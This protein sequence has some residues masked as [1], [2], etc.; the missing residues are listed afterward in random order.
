MFGWIAA[1]PNTITFGAPP[2]AG[3]VITADF[4]FGYACRFTEDVA[5]FEEFMAMLS[6]V[7]TLAFQSVRDIVPFEITALRTIVIQFPDRRRASSARPSD[8]N[9][10]Y[11]RVIAIG[12]GGGGGY[13]ARRVGGGGGAFTY[14]DNVQLDVGQ[15]VPIVIGDG[16]AAA[17]PGG[18]DWGASRRPDL[19]PQSRRPQLRLCRS[20]PASIPSAS[21]RFEGAASA[22]NC[23][24]PRTRRAAAAA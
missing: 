1:Q 20:R 3:T 21:R 19:L 17:R 4:K 7:K 14:R 22:T 5:D 13:D 11:N 9:N 12:G 24:P 18:G 10:N 16:G 6:G 8:W 23:I 15:C 2:P